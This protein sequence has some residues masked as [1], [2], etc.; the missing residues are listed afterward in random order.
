MQRFAQQDVNIDG[1]SPSFMLHLAP[2]KIRCRLA[3]NPSLAAGETYF[4]RAGTGLRSIERNFEWRIV[5]FHLQCGQWNLKIFRLSFVYWFLY[6]VWFINWISQ[7]SNEISKASFKCHYIWLPSYDKGLVLDDGPFIPRT[8]ILPPFAQ[9]ITLWKNPVHSNARRPH[10]LRN[11]L[12]RLS[13]GTNRS[14]ISG[15]WSN[16]STSRET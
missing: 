13:R 9:K 12:Y 16:C 3:G 6:R 1:I 15:K 11:D 7:E 14:C 2:M 10:R 5:V 4:V 8:S